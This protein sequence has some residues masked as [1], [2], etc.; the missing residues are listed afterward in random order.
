MPVS[1]SYD[2]FDDRT[3]YGTGLHLID[4][5]SGIQGTHW[6]LFSY[7]VDPKIEQGHLL[8]LRV[9]EGWIWSDEMRMVVMADDTRIETEKARRVNSTTFFPS[10]SQIDSIDG[11]RDALEMDLTKEQCKALANAKNPIE[12]KAGSLQFSFGRGFMKDITDAVGA[13]E[14]K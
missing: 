4:N 13:H 6:G 1:V 7:S 10:G 14:A 12:G 9:G 3:T 5:H 11:L 8:L 2:K